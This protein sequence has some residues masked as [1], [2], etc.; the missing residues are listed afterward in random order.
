MVLPEARRVFCERLRGQL[1]NELHE[2]VEVLET[3][4]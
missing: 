2:I 4:G 1:S 3:D